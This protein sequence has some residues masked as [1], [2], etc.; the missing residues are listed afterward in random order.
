MPRPSGYSY[1][2]VYIFSTILSSFFRAAPVGVA[3][4][5]GVRNLLVGR[6]S[7]ENCPD[8]S[9]PPL[10][11][12]GPHPDSLSRRLPRVRATAPAQHSTSRPVAA[13]P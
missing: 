9:R 5:D 10:R 3:E 1:V 6:Q 8:A 7:P 12:R 11:G 13:R 2:I 4:R